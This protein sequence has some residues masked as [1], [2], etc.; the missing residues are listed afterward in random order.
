[1]TIN[2]DA[3]PD[4]NGSKLLEKKPY[5][6]TVKK[7]EMKPAKTKNDDGST[8]PDYLNLFLEASTPDG[9]KAGQLWDII[10][11]STNNYAQYKLKRFIIALGVPTTPGMSL[12][13]KDLAKIAPN[14]KM[15]A[16]ITVDDKATPPKNQVDI[17]SGDVYYPISAF[18]E[19]FG[20]DNAFINAE[21]AEDVFNT[22][23]TPEA[24]RHVE[25]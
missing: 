10:T 11:E 12:E 13:L 7:A 20:T 2:F 15:I 5:L 3:L 25:Y 21:D 14:A 1:M 4:S 22:Q 19:V 8:K 17:F 9:K 16:D 24:E 6:I 23:D 18:N